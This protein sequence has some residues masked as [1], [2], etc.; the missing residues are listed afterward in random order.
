MH[1]NTTTTCLLAV[2][3]S[4]AITGCESSDEDV[5]NVQPAASTSTQSSTA[6]STPS[7]SSTTVSTPVNTVIPKNDTA[8]SSDTSAPTAAD[9][10][11][12]GALRWS[13]GGIGGGGASQTSATIK[14]LKVAGQNLS[15]GWGGPNL[16]SWGLSNDDY[17]GAYACLFVQTESGAWVGGKFDWVSSSRTSRNLENVFN[18]YSGWSLANV[19]NPCQVAFVIISA[20]KKKRTNVIASTWKR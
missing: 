7:Q 3:L 15:F 4:A 11:P 1:I 20:D 6:V 14:G 19:P 16:S 9:A 12:Y 13:Y 5:Y 2:I 18:G 17:S 10:V 8:L